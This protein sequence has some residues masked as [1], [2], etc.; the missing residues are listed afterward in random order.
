M[1][2]QARKYKLTLKKT[3]ILIKEF[4]EEGGD[5]IYFF[6]EGRFGLRS[7]TMR[8]WYKKGESAIVKVKQGFKNF[9]IYSSV[10]PKT[11]DDFSLALPCVNTDVMNIYINE[12]KKHLGDKKCL[13]I[14]DGAGWHKS[15]N[16]SIPNNIKI[17]FLPAYS[18]ELNPVERLWKYIKRN[19]VHNRIF[20][21]IDNLLQVVS[22]AFVKLNREKLLA[23]CH[24]SYM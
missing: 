15:K 24:C 13:I 10:S 1:R 21:G 7:T 8:G 16:L 3:N 17:L 5:D 2:K 18:P 9:Y 14:W 20:N 22:E 4:I 12:F 6:D 19:N 23:L 11:G